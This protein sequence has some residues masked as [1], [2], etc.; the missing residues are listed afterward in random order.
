MKKRCLSA[1]CL[2]LCLFLLLGGCT[3]PALGETEFSSD[4]TKLP[5]EPTEKDSYYFVLIS[6]D[7]LTEDDH[8]AISRIIKS[9]EN[10]DVFLLD[11]KGY[12]TAAEVYERLREESLTK[13][14]KL[15][16]IQIFGTP[17]MVPSFVIDDKVSLRDSF[18]TEEAFFS[19]YFYSNFR[20]DVN[21]LESF[22]V[23]DHFASES[24]VSLSPEWRVVRLPLGSGEFSA[25][26][27]DY[28]TYLTDHKAQKPQL[29]CFSSPIFRYHDTYSVD[30]FACFLYRAENEWNLVDSVRLY[31]N[32]MGLYPTP[33]EVLGDISLDNLKKE[34]EAGV[35]EFFLT[36][37][38]SRQEVIRA[39]FTDSNQEHRE[40]YLSYDQLAA[41]LSANPYFLNTHACILAEGLDFN[42]ARSA[43]NNGCLGIF[44]ATSATANNGIDCQVSPD[45]MKDSGNYF[46][47]YYL[48]LKGR[49]DGLSRSASFFEAQKGYEGCLAL[50]A[51][52]GID[53]SANYQFGYANLLLYANLG[54]LEPEADAL[55]SGDAYTEENGTL[56]LGTNTVFLST[57]KEIGE[58]ISLPSEKK[59]YQGTHSV[60]VSDIRAV[61]LDNGYIRFHLTVKTNKDT[62]LFVCDKGLSKLIYEHLILTNEKII[63]SA[64]IPREELERDRSIAFAFRRDSNLSAWLISDLKGLLQVS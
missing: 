39:Y 22:T 15:D 12:T 42:F 18:H 17:D 59:L 21:D 34:N 53:Y 49:K 38:G 10:H 6:S 9:Y 16:G 52:K 45:S 24:K 62:T 14:G 19:D 36:G 58:W 56:P 50:C 7:C 57:G 31:A 3:S 28:Q 26:V 11:V 32:Q 41:V 55:P 1:V 13:S 5:S 33:V 44:A 60:T 54:I 51:Q 23:A 64:D 20:N 61:A 40:V 4:H 37:H 63:L 2:F 35:A 25:Y 47:F 29:V 30:D 48:Y 27:S 43:L 8:T 46:Y